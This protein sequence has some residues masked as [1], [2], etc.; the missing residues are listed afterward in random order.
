VE[1]S[2]LSVFGDLILFCLSRKS[3]EARISH[4]ESFFVRAEG[5]ELFLPV[6][7]MEVQGLEVRGKK[8]SRNKMVHSKE[9]V[10]ACQGIFLRDRGSLA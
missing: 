6:F 2:K 1:N 7:E 8:A 9:F 5:E 3:G 4:L 10:R